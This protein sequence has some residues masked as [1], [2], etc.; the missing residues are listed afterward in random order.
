[1]FPMTRR[2]RRR[3]PAVPRRAADSRA[4]RSDLRG[5]R[6]RI[7]I[8]GDRPGSQRRRLL[9]PRWRLRRIPGRQHHGAEALHHL[10][11]GLHPDPFSTRKFTFRN[12]GWGGDTAWL[13]QRAHP[14]EGK[15]FAAKDDEQQK[16]VEK[17]VGTG[18][19][20]DVLP[21]KPTA[22]TVDFGMNDHA[23]TKFREDIFRAY[24]AEPGGN[25]QGP[26][27]AW[28][29]RGPAHAPADRGTPPR[30]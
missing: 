1:M 16:M 21:L 14:D 10:H 24:F 13:R 9:F 23:Y 20:R 6:A 19:A 26:H 8:L 3:A 18:L 27:E 17:A 12:V 25:R 29:P 11:R 28:R 15:L 22:V 5:N 2:P 4:W 7:V 30:S